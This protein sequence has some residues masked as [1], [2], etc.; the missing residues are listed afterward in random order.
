MRIIGV[1]VDIRIVSIPTGVM[2]SA[3]RK[4]TPFTTLGR[5]LIGER[6]RI[7]RGELELEDHLDEAFFVLASKRS[8]RL[9]G[10]MR[11]PEFL[12]FL[13]IVN[14]SSNIILIEEIILTDLCTRIS[15]VENLRS[16]LADA[17]PL[18]IEV[19]IAAV[20]RHVIAAP[21]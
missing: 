8:S 5:L 14:Q 10:R 17:A 13:G 4:S 2:D 6:W 18:L 12:L 11:V 16:L 19:A 3:F 7:A 15:L 9:P 1:L 20:A 21:D